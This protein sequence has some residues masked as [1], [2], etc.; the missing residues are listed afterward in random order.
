MPA[1]PAYS[2]AENG[3]GTSGL[4]NGHSNLEVPPAPGA[5][6]TDGADRAYWTNLEVI[7]VDLLPEKEGWFLQKYRVE[8][9]VSSIALSVV[10]VDTV[11]LIGRLETG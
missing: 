2:V 7:E 10:L 5:L 3:W 9:D 4:E 11:Q 6:E 8:S 1:A